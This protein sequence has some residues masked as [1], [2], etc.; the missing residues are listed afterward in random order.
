M[1]GRF[2]SC[3]LVLPAFRTSAAKDTGSANFEARSRA[4]YLRV[5]KVGIRP[6]GLSNLKSATSLVAERNGFLTTLPNS[7]AQASP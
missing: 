6:V 7:P 5:S 3:S 1:S 2:I 4:S